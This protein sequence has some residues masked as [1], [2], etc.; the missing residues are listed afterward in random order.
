MGMVQQVSKSLCILPIC[1][2][3]LS[4][5]RSSM[6]AS[7]KAGKQGLRWATAQAHNT[8]AEHGVMHGQA[9]AWSTRVSSQLIGGM[10]GSVGEY[11]GE[12]GEAL[13]AAADGL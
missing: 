13:G 4:Q 2:N 1:W 12:A 7:G 10:P 9:R 11:L 3:L 5:R 8:V 6:A